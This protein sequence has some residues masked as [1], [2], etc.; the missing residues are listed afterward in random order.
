MT[1][2]A[3]KKAAARGEVLIS[4]GEEAEL[5]RSAAARAVSFVPRAGAGRRSLRAQSLEHRAQRRA[6]Q[7]PLD[8]VLVVARHPGRN[9]VVRFGGLD[10]ARHRV[11]Q[12]HGTGG[13]AHV[14]H[15]GY[16]SL[17]HVGDQFSNRWKGQPRFPKRVLLNGKKGA[18][19][20]EQLARE[21]LTPPQLG[22]SASAVRPRFSGER[23]RRHHIFSRLTR[24]ALNSGV[25][26]LASPT[27]GVRALAS[28]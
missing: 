16:H 28:Q 25:R 2:S 10:A 21:W 4:A 8:H 15:G 19:E 26:A 7:I 5:R 1:A 27:K 24:K 13:N 3:D 23:D 11:A 6:R 14:N 12:L 18:I 20:I 22:R 9:Q 17:D